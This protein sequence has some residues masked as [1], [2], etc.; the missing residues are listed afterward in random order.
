MRSGLKS[1]SW[2]FPRHES[3][4]SS[5]LPRFAIS[6]F[7]VLLAHR[8]RDGLTAWTFELSPRCTLA[9]E[10]AHLK[11]DIDKEVSEGEGDH[12]SPSEIDTWEILCVWRGELAFGREGGRRA[13][14]NE[15]ESWLYSA[16]ARV[17]HDLWMS[18]RVV[19]RSEAFCFCICQYRAGSDLSFLC[20]VW[21]HGLI[22]SAVFKYWPQKSG[23]KWCS[24]QNY[25]N[26]SPRS[27]NILYRKVRLLRTCI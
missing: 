8:K 27:N 2:W 5:F 25:G 11:E 23:K 9:S 15:G 20:H 14:E 4:L 3:H 12:R 1:S 17:C 13:Y 21:K 10:S 22:A 24:I 7:A 26:I 18:L 16:S 6:I 19:R